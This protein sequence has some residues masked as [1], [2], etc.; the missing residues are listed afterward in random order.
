M[1]S[2]E[3]LQAQK[4]TQFPFRLAAID[5]DNTLLGPDKQIS[6]ANAAAVQALRDRGVHIVLASGRR[7]ENML[8]F[9]QQLGLRGPIVSA[10]GA[11]VKDAETGE[12]LH[13]QTVP[14][15]LA[16][17]I[18]ANG[19]THGMTIIYY[20]SDGVHVRDRNEWTD[21][22]QRRAGETVI[23]HGDLSDLAGD[24]PQKVIWCGPPE[25][26][27]ALFDP[28]QQ[29]YAG[30]L[31]LIITDPEFLEFTATGVHKAVGLSAVAQ[32]Y[33][34]TPAQVLAF[35]DGNND[36]TMLQWAG[37]GVAM[38]HA[39]PSAHAVAD[40]IAPPG[41]PET[42]FARAVDAVLKHIQP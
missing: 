11:L 25:Q 21:L 42:D 35:G 15:N 30:R 31:D 16:A 2:T 10:Q 4:A 8:R 29:H 38:S 32:R 6:E 17:E 24:R 40:L 20:R 1:N 33:G 14:A 36:V 18:V 19:P 3:N 7:H 5:L 12:I 37:L 22:Y 41:N 27:T 13:Q 26:V 9:H 34:I 39:R 23:V 28:M